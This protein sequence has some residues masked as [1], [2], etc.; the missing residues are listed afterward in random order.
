MAGLAVGVAV[1]SAR[2]VVVAVFVLDLVRASPVHV[3]VVAWLVVGSVL[4][5]VH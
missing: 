5:C 3:V 2:L 1:S 4:L